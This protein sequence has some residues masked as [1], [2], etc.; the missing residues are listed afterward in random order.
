MVKCVTLNL[1]LF[2][3]FKRIVGKLRVSNTDVCIDAGERRE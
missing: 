1:T 3:N 2:I